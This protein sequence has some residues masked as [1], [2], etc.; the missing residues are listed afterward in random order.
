MVGWGDAW[1]AQGGATGLAQGVLE[2][3]M[4]QRVL[5]HWSL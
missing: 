2:A 5:E 3:T 1:R 4:G